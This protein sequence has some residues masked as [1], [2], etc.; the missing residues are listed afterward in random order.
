MTD[1]NAPKNNSQTYQPPWVIGWMNTSVGKVA[2]VGSELLFSDRVGSWKARWAVGRMSY[3]VEPGLYALGHPDK[4]SPVLVTANYKMSFDCLRSQMGG[5]NA[6]IL[7]LNTYGINVWC[8]AGKGTFGTDELT[9][10]IKATRIK[11]AVSHRNIIL[12]QLGA[13]G[14][15]AYLVKKNTGFRVKYGPVRAADLPKYLDSGLKSSKEM[16][17]VTFPFSDRIAL[18]P[19]ELVMSFKP[20]VIAFIVLLVLGGFGKGIFSISRMVSHVSCAFVLMTSALILGAV[21]T[22][23][24]LPW[25]PGRPF[26]LKGALTGMAGAVILHHLFEIPLL[27]SSGIGGILLLTTFSSFL[28]MN[29]TGAS[30]YTSFSGVKK[31]MGIAV[32]AQIITLIC[33]LAFLVNG[34]LA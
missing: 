7:V 34:Y 12:P 4:D 31:E 27:N 17:L 9:K 8:A 20:A 23:A 25:I 28:A 29:F 22:P 16:R 14:V 30:T 13:P 5:R 10:Q 26:S 15:A 1:K 24:L 3:S 6:W 18:T 11:D 21:V 2:Q 33:G 32:P 19:V